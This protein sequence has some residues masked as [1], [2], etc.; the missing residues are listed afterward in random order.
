[1]CY[2]ICFATLKDLTA[3]MFLYYVYDK[4]DLPEA[5]WILQPDSC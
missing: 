3:T 4:L 1:M 2:Y 5:I